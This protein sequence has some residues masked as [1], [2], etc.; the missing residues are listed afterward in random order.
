VTIAAVDSRGNLK[1]ASVVFFVT[2]ISFSGRIVVRDGRIGKTGAV[3]AAICP[4]AWTDPVARGRKK[5]S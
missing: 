5:V 2:R 3:H 1:E 4:Q